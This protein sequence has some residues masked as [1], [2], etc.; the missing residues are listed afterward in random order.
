MKKNLI[1]SKLINQLNVL[2]FFKYP[3]TLGNILLFI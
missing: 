2:F 1:S 3:H